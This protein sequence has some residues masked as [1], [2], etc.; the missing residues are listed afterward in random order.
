[1]K[2]STHANDTARKKMARYLAQRTCG[3]W[4]HPSECGRVSARE[5]ACSPSPPAEKDKL[6]SAARRT[7][8][9]PPRHMDTAD[10]V[11]VMTPETRQTPLETS[12]LRHEKK[13][14]SEVKR[15]GQFCVHFP[16][17]KKGPKRV[18]PNSWGSH[19]WSLFR[20]R[21]MVPILR[22]LPRRG[23]ALPL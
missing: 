7:H 13:C 2:K 22:P 8:S 6:P 16:D 14:H 4:H 23:H 10:G 9:Q 3:P 20:V 21:K 19:L 1:M 18:N 17:A 12:P 11:P 15:R 5:R